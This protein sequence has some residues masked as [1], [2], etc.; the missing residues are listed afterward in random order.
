MQNDNYIILSACLFV[1]LEESEKR[2][3]RL[4]KKEKESCEEEELRTAVCH[5]NSLLDIIFCDEMKMMK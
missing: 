3:Q 1:Q 5:F 4:E 2:L